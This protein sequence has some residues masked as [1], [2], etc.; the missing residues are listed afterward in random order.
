MSQTNKEEA[1]EKTGHHEK[2]VHHK[3]LFIIMGSVAF[4]AVPTLAASAPGDKHHLHRKQIVRHNQIG[5]GSEH[6]D[7]GDKGDSG[8]AANR[9]SG[10]G[11]SGGSAGG[12]SGK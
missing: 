1:R 6:G 7:R 12:G 8:P 9:D 5:G 3:K 2:T 10:G 4:I 11:K